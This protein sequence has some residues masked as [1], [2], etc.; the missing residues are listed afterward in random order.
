[1]KRMQ[2]AGA[3]LTATLVAAAGPALA[4]DRARDRDQTRDQTQDRDYQ[5][6]QDRAHEQ[7]RI[8]GSQLMSEQERKEHRLQMRSAKSAEERERI[9]AEH[10]ERMKLRAKERGM[11]LPD[12]PPPRG[13]GGGMGPGPRY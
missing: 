2:F 10:H 11:A 3:L 6:D 5:R 12:D 1:M 4:E 7:E 8:F 9:R 13:M